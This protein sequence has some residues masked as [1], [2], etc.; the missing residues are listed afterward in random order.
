MAG[1]VDLL[2]L[3][4]DA[5]VKGAVS[6]F[7]KLEGT[8]S[9]SLDG[10]ERQSKSFGQKFSGGFSAIGSSLASSLGP[11]AIASTV[12]AGIGIAIKSASDL[13]E[14][15]SKTKS[16]FG[17]SSGAILKWA[18]G[19][20]TSIGQSKTQALEAASSFGNMFLQLG[21]TQGAAVNMSTAMTGLASDFASFFNSSP[22]EALDAISSAFRGEF[23]AVQRFVPT[24]SA[25]TV[26]QEALKEGLAKT[27]KE[28]TQ[29]DKAT[30][31]YNLLL[32]GAGQ[33]T[34]DFGRT[35]DSLANQQRILKAQLSDT[36]AEIG[37]SLLPAM[38]KIAQT[39]NDAIGWLETLG[40]KV[41]DLD[42]ASGRG[43]GGLLG[44]LTGNKGFDSKSWSEFFG[45]AS[46]AKDVPP[47]IDSITKSVD[48]LN[49]SVGPAANSVGDFGRNVD[50][51][52][53]GAATGTDI[54]TKSI[55]ALGHE[56]GPAGTALGDLTRSAGSVVTSM[57]M[58][59]TSADA[60]ANAISRTGSEFGDL[61]QKS[62]EAADAINQVH[63][64]ISGLNDAQLD[65]AE[66]Q[67]RVIESM[68]KATKAAKDGKTTALEKQVAD[69]DAVKAA[70]ALAENQLEIAQ[71]TSTA[72]TA[73]GKAND[74]QKAYL[75]TLTFIAA[76]AQPKVREGIY[77]LIAAYTTF[78]Q[79]H[80]KPTAD[81]D[82]TP[83]VNKL[84]D[85]QRKVD[86]LDKSRPKPVLDATDNATP[87]ISP[88]QAALNNISKHYTST[89]DVGVNTGGA[90]AALDALRNRLNSAASQGVLI[91]GRSNLH[92]TFAQGGLVPG[93][94]N[95][96]QFA[97]VHG[98]EY[99]IPSNLVEAI[100]K[101][102]P[103]SG[104][105]AMPKSAAATGGGRSIVVNV[106]GAIV[107]Q[108]GVGRAVK[109]AIAAAERAGVN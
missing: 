6:E 41:Q 88:V 31:T 78:G 86:A 109:Q 105:S 17:E 5:D 108:I 73:Q 68:E 97:M 62:Q 18:D 79:Q 37:N 81:A 27:T 28:L 51:H 102:R 92:L 15:V 71:A 72:T 61:E 43:E 93:Y 21:L 58:V 53:R 10:V 50:E 45:F 4:V 13:N 39:A 23:D 89:I 22:E 83:A 47:H 104:P 7:K 26:E 29:Q 85:T 9:S 32:K 82:V 8:A 30:A 87:K 96:P 63:D 48:E 19:A 12:G 59:P 90:N 75:D 65:S 60:A 2:K 24:I 55:S 99:V 80:P 57:D 74:G 11:A 100:R 38:V 103:P 3:V 1:F 36:A 66:L 64:A 33:A 20:A 25:A 76:S 54:M 49:A 46:K 35:S 84:A 91:N 52:F 34:G 70:K 56:I 67:Q 94:R 98:G 40:T 42:K 44:K 69:N 106:N 107:D 77:E 101:G 95:Q 16:V 14:Q